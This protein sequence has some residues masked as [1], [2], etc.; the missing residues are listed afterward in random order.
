MII[1]KSYGEKYII[2][3]VTNIETTENNTYTTLTGKLIEQKGC[4][5]FLNLDELVLHMTDAVEV[6]EP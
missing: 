5:K 4:E 2:M 1:K 3:K 6:I